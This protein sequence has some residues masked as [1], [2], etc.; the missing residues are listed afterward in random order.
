[1]RPMES[2][3]IELHLIQREIL[4]FFFIAISESQVR[5]ELAEEE[6]DR[7]EQGGVALH[8]TSA[9]AFIIH[10]LELEDAQYVSL[11]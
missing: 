2:V 6:R 1:M 11:Q 8:V 7:I 3:S 5:K 10:G 4:M 9:S